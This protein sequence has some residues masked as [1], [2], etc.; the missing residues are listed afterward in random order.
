EKILLTIL[1]WALGNAEG[2]LLVTQI[3]RGGALIR[4]M[5]RPVLLTVDD[6]PEVLRAIER[7]LRRKYANNFRVLR[8]DSGAAGLDIVRE[9]KVRNNVV[10]LFLID[11][12]MPGMSGV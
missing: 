2:Y 10:A 5:A 9:L 8:A 3:N 6:D 1:N 4:V 11:Q 7:D 12:R